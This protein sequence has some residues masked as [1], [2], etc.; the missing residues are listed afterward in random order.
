MPANKKQTSFVD[1]AVS[2]LGIGILF[3][4]LIIVSGGTYLYMRYSNRQTN[5]KKL[6]SAVVPPT[7]TPTPTRLYP[8]EGNTGI[9]SVSTGQ[10]T[11]PRITKVIFS[12]LDAKK[13][14]PLTISTVITNDTPVQ[15]VTGVFS[16]DSSTLNVIFTLESRTDKT[17]TW[18][19]TI[20]SLPDSVSYKYG[21]H[22]T[23]TAANGSGVGGANPRSR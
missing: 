18:K 21:I 7:P 22:I 11:G 16:M 13:G 6:A 3:L 8:N 4:V 15:K 23:A 1:T 17:E 9:Y 10:K 12:P 14:A 20:S 19:T 5:E 2:P